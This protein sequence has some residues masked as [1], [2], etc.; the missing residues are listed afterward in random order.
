MKERERE[1]RLLSLFSCDEGRRMVKVV[2]VFI[3]LYGITRWLKD[4]LSNSL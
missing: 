4:C 3:V 1:T 2:V